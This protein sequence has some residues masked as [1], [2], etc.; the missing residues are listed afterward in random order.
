MGC[1]SDKLWFLSLG[2]QSLPPT[3]LFACPRL[4]FSGCILGLLLWRVRAALACL[5]KPSTIAIHHAPGGRW[6]ISLRRWHTSLF[7]LNSYIIFW[8]RKLRYKVIKNGSL[9]LASN[10]VECGPFSNDFPGTLDLNLRMHS[11]GIS[12]PGSSTGVGG[13]S[14]SE[15]VCATPEGNVGTSRIIMTWHPSK[16][17]FFKY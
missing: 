14:E 3:Q 9:C 4:S 2:T 5:I 7:Q 12:V 10:R 16:L 15:C 13:A 1:S 6:P 8:T 17:L 11:W